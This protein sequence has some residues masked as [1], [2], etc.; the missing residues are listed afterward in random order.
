MSTLSGRTKLAD[1]PRWGLLMEK[2]SPLPN[3]T[4]SIKE[5]RSN[6]FQFPWL[7]CAVSTRLKLR[8]KTNAPCPA[9]M[10]VSRESHTNDILLKLFNS[11]N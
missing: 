11:V 5:G 6:H 1:V 10:R 9:R 7:V 8:N 3:A 2:D 4:G